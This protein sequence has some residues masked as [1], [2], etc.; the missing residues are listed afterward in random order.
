MKTLGRT[1]P[2][3]SFG[4]RCP[5]RAAMRLDD[6]ERS[7]LYRGEVK[8]RNAPRVGVQRDGSSQ[9]GAALKVGALPSRARVDLPTCTGDARQ[10][11]RCPLRSRTGLSTVRRARIPWSA[12][13]KIFR[14]I[15]SWVAGWRLPG[16]DS[17]GQVVRYIGVA[18]VS[19]CDEQAPARPFGGAGSIWSQKGICDPRAGNQHSLARPSRTAGGRIFPVVWGPHVDPS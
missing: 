2:A 12:K 14:P 19:G 17:L 11:A 1:A 5:E 4:R 10:K 13:V 15:P 18:N 16:H 3:T 9:A 6:W 7:G 8:N